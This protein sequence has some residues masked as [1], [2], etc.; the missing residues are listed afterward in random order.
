MGIGAAV[1]LPVACRAFV[2]LALVAVAF[3]LAML[4]ERI[5]NKAKWNEKQI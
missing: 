3:V 2:V 5:S 1:L 4:A